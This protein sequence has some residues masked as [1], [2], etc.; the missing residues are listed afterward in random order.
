MKTVLSV[1][2]CF[3]V[4]FILSGCRDG[5]DGGSSGGPGDWPT[6]SF[7]IDDNGN[8]TCFGADTNAIT[9][10]QTCVWNCAYYNIPQPRYVQLWFDEGLVC[11]ETATS[12]TT[13]TTG[14]PTTTTA[15]TTENCTTQLS[16][17]RESFKPCKLGNPRPF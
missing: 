1:L 4:I 6:V 11:T 15:T 14:T 9:T 12:S 13:S 2:C 10:R 8:V 7:A 5:D 16:L 3:A 17:V